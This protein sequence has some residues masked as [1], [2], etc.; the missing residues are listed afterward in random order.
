MVWKKFKGVKRVTVVATVNSAPDANANIQPQCV[1][2]SEHVVTQKAASGASS[3][4]ANFTPGLKDG[5]K[6]KQ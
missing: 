1:L 4:A 3:M 5:R 2:E 6:A